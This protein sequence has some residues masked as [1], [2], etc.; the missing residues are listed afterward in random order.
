MNLIN[1]QIKIN[2]LIVKILLI[3]I[4]EYLIVQIREIIQ[5]IIK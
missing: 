4:I 5:N 3:I 2:Y 1:F